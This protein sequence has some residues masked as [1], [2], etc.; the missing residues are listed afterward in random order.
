MNATPSPEMKQNNVERERQP[1]LTASQS[2]SIFSDALVGE[3]KPPVIAVSAPLPSNSH[4]KMGFVQAE[5][6]DYSL[7]SNRFNKKIPLQKQM[8]N[9]PTAVI[10]QL[11]SKSFNKKLSCNAAQASQSPSNETTSPRKMEYVPTSSRLNPA[12][13]SDNKK[14]GSKANYEEMNGNTLHN[15][16]LFVQSFSTD[17][18][19]NCHA[20]I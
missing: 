7:P 12:K 1:L 9:D 15:N 19:G 6:I 2:P 14:V 18:D 4:N 11:P 20:D 3:T 17:S 13:S 5:S 10:G 8:M 16:D